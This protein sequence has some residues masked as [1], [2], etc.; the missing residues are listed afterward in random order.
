MPRELRFPT[1]DCVSCLRLATLV[2]ASSC[3]FLFAWRGVFDRNENLEWGRI[4]SRVI[5]RSLWRVDLWNVEEKLNLGTAC[6]PHRDES[7][8]VLWALWTDALLDV[9]R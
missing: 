9:T 5:G 8:R 4:R 7:Y 6:V 3:L 2:A 1:Q